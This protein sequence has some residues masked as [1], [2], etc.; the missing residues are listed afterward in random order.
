MKTG[1]GLTLAV[2]TRRVAWAALTVALF[3]GTVGAQ[4]APDPI[5][6]AVAT[7][8]AGAQT[9][10]PPATLTFAN[11]RIVELRAT[12]A[13]RPPAV[14]AAMAAQTIGRLAEQNPDAQ[15]TMHRYEQGIVLSVADQPVIVVFA[16]D[17]DPLAGETVSGKADAA[18]STLAVAMG[19]AAELRHPQRL[20]RGAL[21]ALVATILYGL[22]IWMLIRVDIK[23]ASSLTDATERGLKRLPGGE[24]MVIARAPR[25]VRRLLTVLGVLLGLLLT[26]SWLAIV[27]R[28]FP[29]TRPWGESLRSG[30][31]SAAAGAGRGLLN[32][33]PNLVTVLAI[34][35]F[36]RLAV[37]LVNFAFRVIEE[38]R[39]TMPGVHPETA[40]PTR[41]IAVTLL[42]LF[43]LVVAYDYLPGAQSDVFKGVSVFIGLIISI[44]SSGVMNQVMSGMMVTYSR[45]LRL[46][47]F[48]R[49]GEVEGTVTHLGTLS[50]KVRNARNE[51]ITIPNAV[52]ASSP[53]VNF[54]RHAE[55]D[56][57]FTP[58]S[59]TIGYDTP[60]RQVQA[61]LLL[62]AERTASVRP[63]PKP[64]VLQTALTDFYVNYTLLVCVESPNRR[65]ATLNVL[66]ANIQDAFNE[67]GV[68][69]MSPNYEADPEGRKV[70]PQTQWYAA[71]AA[72]PS[73]G[74]KPD[75]TV[76]TRAGSGHVEVG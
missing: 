9:A 36:T 67:F 14:R 72:P 2:M 70:V 4:T 21:V 37:R 52:V 64:F 12:I 11:R 5:G 43:A 28:R 60:W 8:A 6:A 25:L 18:A 35:L 16:A 69:I 55:T 56:G 34:I 76:A 29:Y 63:E 54:S 58:T 42:W 40:Q 61:L 10:D 31:F 41:R 57:V 73:L 50:T 13:S 1:D 68:Q 3:G 30:L 26:Y 49:I 17:A 59:V 27:L 65:M 74:A 48:V 15:V 75:A 51:E 7:A 33:A 62:A 32:Q 46:G 24:I 20:V 47:D 44:G 71:P 53:A 19:E 45:A 23:V 38:G 39:V 22:A 66:H